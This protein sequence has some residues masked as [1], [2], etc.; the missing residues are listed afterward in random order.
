M[1]SKQEVYLQEVEFADIDEGWW[2]SVLSDEVHDTTS[3]CKLYR[4]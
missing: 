3:K 2:E 1:L 4:K